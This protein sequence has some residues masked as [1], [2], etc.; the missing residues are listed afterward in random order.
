M[1]L[2]GTI[3]EIRGDKDMY[4]PRTVSQFVLLMATIA[5]IAILYPAT[6]HGNMQDKKIPSS[7]APKPT[8]PAGKSPV[9]RNTTGT[10]K[11]MTEKPINSKLLVFT[12]N[13]GGTTVTNTNGE[14]GSTL[15]D[16]AM[17]GNEFAL[18]WTRT[19]PGKAEK[20]N[21]LVTRKVKP[22][23]GEFGYLGDGVLSVTMPAKSTSVNIPFSFS[24]L[25][26]DP[27]LPADTYELMV[28]GETGNSTKVT[29]NYNGKGSK[30][31]S[32]VL[33][34]GPTDGHVATSKGKVTA[35]Q[36][37][38]VVG[39]PNEPGYKTAKLS[40]TLEAETDWQINE[41]AV[42]VY[43]EP[44]I[45]SE[46]VTASGSK[47]API[48][49]FSGTWKIPS[50]TTYTIHPGTPKVISIQLHRTSKGQVN[51]LEA[52]PGIYSPADWKIAFGQTTTASFRWIVDG[53]PSGSVEQS[54]KKQWLWP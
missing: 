1:C 46:V 39:S 33:K 17:V 12:V 48:K 9:T 20:G 38:P 52:G 15:A 44:F 18:Q 14:F 28:L 8:G 34:P 5:A 51:A 3:K 45:N 26:P 11:P 23:G 50:A 10:P 54:P 49:L 32:I 7:A 21:L 36:F 16:S 47:N 22:V 35:A 2:P 40:L 41:I 37:T 29:V 31:S 42:E 30:G 53:K 4:R 6:S 19:N 43:S 24:S 27:Q 13:G 25:E